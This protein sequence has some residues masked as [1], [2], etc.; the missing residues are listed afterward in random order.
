MYMSIPVKLTKKKFGNSYYW[1]FDKKVIDLLK[2]N[3]FDTIDVSITGFNKS[4]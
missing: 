3:D 2:I 1:V 4:K